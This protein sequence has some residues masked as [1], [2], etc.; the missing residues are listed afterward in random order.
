M[1]LFDLAFGA[2]PNK[3][4]NP[5][6]LGTFD[7]YL[8]CI[9]LLLFFSQYYKAVEFILWI[10]QRKHDEVV[11]YLGRHL[12]IFYTLAN[13]P[14]NTIQMHLKEFRKHDNYKRN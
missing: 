1:I 8:D 14:K 7:T 5:I 3:V 13:R 4:S 12:I 6:Y 11:F 9:H 2:I 10:Y